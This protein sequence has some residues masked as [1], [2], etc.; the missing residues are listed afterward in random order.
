M[1]WEALT[2]WLSPLALPTVVVLGCAVALWSDRTR[3]RKLARKWG[4]PEPSADQV[5]EVLHYRRLRLAGYPLIFVVAAVCCR[6]LLPPNPEHADETGQGSYLALVAMFFFGAVI[7]ELLAIARIRKSQPMRLHLAEIAPRWGVGFCGALVPATFALGLI[8][9]QAQ[10]H[11][12]P[13]MLLLAEQNKQHT[14]TPI[15][16][17]FV[18]TALVALL[19]MFVLWSARTRSFSADAELDRAL[20]NRSARV[21]LGLGIGMQVSFL[22]LV[23]WR[24]DF[25]SRFA[26]GADLSGAQPAEVVLENWARGMV[27]LVQPW[28]LL[29]V[30]G[31]MFGWL[32]VANPGKAWR[33]HRTR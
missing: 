18:G 15:A 32:L 19:V 28:L 7:A 13:N 25:L 3:A 22:G 20:R 26:T 30:T 21:V 9:L 17:P 29:V 5:D 4:V 14:G 6:L 33:T 12:T 24:M 27:D 11:I 1:D 23:W 10:P 8:D 16:V 2:D 31:G